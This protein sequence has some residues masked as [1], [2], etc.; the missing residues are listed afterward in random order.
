MLFKLI[1]Y[2]RLSR[3]VFIASSAQTDHIQRKFQVFVKNAHDGWNIR[4]STRGISS[5][6]QVK[7]L[8]T[9]TIGTIQTKSLATAGNFDH[10]QVI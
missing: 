5:S 10:F 4:R 1:L 7:S 6:Q 2:F 3:Q 9:P 8:L